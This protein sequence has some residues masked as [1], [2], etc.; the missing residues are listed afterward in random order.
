MILSG[1]LK[2]WWLEWADEETIILNKMWHGTCA[3]TSVEEMILSGSLKR[4]CLEKE[5]IDLKKDAARDTCM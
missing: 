3:F 4:R 2:R 5:I 1:P